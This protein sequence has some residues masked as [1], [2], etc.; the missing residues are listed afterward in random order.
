M[1]KILTEERKL[2]ISNSLK[3]TKERRKNQSIKVIELKVNCHHTS[4]EDFEKIYDIFKQCKYVYNDML[5]FGEIENNDIFSY[6]YNDHKTI[7]RFDKD[8]NK[9][10]EKL[11]LNSVYHRGMVKQVKTN[12]SNLSKAKKK[13]HKVGRLRY[14]SEINSV[15]IITGFIKIKDKNHIGIPS[16]KNLC[17]Y[18]LE[19]LNGLTDYEIAD[20]KLVNRPSGIYVL[21]TVCINKKEKISKQ[22]T[23]KSVGLDFGTRKDIATSDGEIFDCNVQE[24]EYLKF[25]QEQLHRKVKGSK[26]YY[27]LRNQILKEYEH[28]CNKKTDMSNKLIS[29]LKKD[30][31]MIYFQDEN[32]KS[33]KKKKRHNKKLSLGKQ[34]QSSFL[35][36]VKTKLKELEKEDKAFMIS[37]WVPTTKFCQKCGSLNDIGDNETYSCPCGYSEDRDF[38]ASKN[39]KLFGSTKRAECLEQASVE[40]TSSVGLKI[41]SILQDVS[42]K[43]KQEAHRF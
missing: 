3:A 7:I 39:V 34:I 43:R 41:K 6:E 16:F 17:V 30:Y 13:G 9:I 12:I 23:N 38:H 40:T 19:Q 4:K 5:S 29:H 2:T 22:K 42:V 32:I 33:W 26:R 28:L 1:K 20:G 11:D 24:N 37:K 35:G 15:S 18:G 27:R 31:D 36:R 14:V 25:L 10:E 8:R 21:L